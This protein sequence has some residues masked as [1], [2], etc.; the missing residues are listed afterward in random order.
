[1]LELCYSL[2][3]DDTF[4]ASQPILFEME[5]FLSNIKGL[6]INSPV[7]A[8]VLGFWKEMHND[9]CLFLCM[10]T[11][12]NVFLICNILQISCSVITLQHSL[13]I[14]PHTFSIA[15][16]CLSRLTVVSRVAKKS[17]INARAIIKTRLP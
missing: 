9:Q 1:M 8:W 12:R 7:P 3:V 14:Q 16:L 17:R 4:M 6:L 13:L 5:L 10:T 15:Y 11:N 2:R